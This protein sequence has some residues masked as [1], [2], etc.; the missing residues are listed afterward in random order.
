ME[1]SR[2]IDMTLKKDIDSSKTDFLRSVAK[3]ILSKDFKRQ[4]KM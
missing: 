2:L 4:L 3:N 1:E